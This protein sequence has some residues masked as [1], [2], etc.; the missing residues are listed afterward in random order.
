MNL[1]WTSILTIIS[2]ILLLSHVCS[3]YNLYTPLC[4]ILSTLISMV[5]SCM[6]LPPGNSHSLPSM[7][8]ESIMFL[9]KTVSGSRFS[10]GGR[11]ER[12]LTP[13]TLVVVTG[14]PKTNINSLRP[15]YTP[16]I[17]TLTLHKNTC[18]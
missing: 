6:T 8:A 16:I 4:S 12:G 11:R 2:S 3:E 9:V 14:G 17:T 15:C 5:S 13:K 18:S 1:L 7:L 10:N